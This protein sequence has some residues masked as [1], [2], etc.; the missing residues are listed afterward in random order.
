MIVNYGDFS[1]ASVSRMD[2]LAGASDHPG[3]DLIT[4]TRIRNAASARF[5]LAAVASEDGEEAPAGD[6]LR[7]HQRRLD[8]SG[9]KLAEISPARFLRIDAAARSGEGASQDEILAGV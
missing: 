3:T 9:E 7:G 4:L 6:H 2:T 1:P 8:G 5:A